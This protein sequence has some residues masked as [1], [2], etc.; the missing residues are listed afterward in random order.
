M[1]FFKTISA[2]IILLTI[3]SNINAQ[4]TFK[5]TD[6]ISQDLILSVQGGFGFGFSDYKNSALGAA[7]QG[8]I[9]YYPIIIQDARLG[10]K[11]YGGGLQLNFSDPRNSISSL[12]E[13]RNIESPIYTDIIQLGAGLSFGYAL[14]QSVVPSITIGTAY[15]NFSPKI[16]MEKS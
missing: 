12:G 8:S 1:K 2:F 11:V 10:F 3:S 7:V 4:L 16:L 9:E 15:L 5:E 14:S 6:Y 13:P